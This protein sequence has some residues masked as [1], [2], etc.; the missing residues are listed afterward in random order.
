[1][2]FGPSP[3]R[4]LPPL[5]AGDW[6]DGLAALQANTGQPYFARVSRIAFPAVKNT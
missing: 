4:V 2:T 5:P 1:M 6:N 3:A